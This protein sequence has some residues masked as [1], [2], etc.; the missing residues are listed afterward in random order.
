MN[1]YSLNL[2]Y[3]IDGNSTVKIQINKPS[4]PLVT[5]FQCVY[6]GQLLIFF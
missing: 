5:I 6:G 1:F 4:L 2:L 3:L